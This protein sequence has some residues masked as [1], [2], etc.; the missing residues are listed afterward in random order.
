MSYS[1]YK[2]LIC[3]EGGRLTYYE[4]SRLI[5]DRNTGLGEDADIYEPKPYGGK[6]RVYPYC[7]VREDGTVELSER[8]DY[9][10]GNIPKLIRQVPDDILDLIKDLKKN[11]RSRK[12]SKDFTSWLSEV[13]IKKSI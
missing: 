7:R 10:H 5:I 11:P 4:Y 6:K 12:H 8:W 13:A 9:T 3:K 2:M 1:L